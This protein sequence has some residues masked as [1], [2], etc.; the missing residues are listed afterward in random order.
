MLLLLPVD[1]L[2]ISAIAVLLEVVPRYYSCISAPSIDLDLLLKPL[3]WEDL[4]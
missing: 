2:D 3:L 1:E 4:D